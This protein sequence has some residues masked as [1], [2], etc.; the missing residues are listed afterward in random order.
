[1]NNA[2][3]NPPA[4][5]SRASSR[6]RIYR[7]EA[8]VLSRFD[9]GETDRVFTLLTRDRGKIRAIAKG[10]RKPTSKLAPSLDYFNRC[11]VM[12]SRG[13][14]LDV[15]TSV[16]VIEHREAFGERVTAF[17]HACHLAEVTGRL[18]PEGQDVPEVYQLLSAA[19]TELERPVE[20]W[21]LARWYEMALLT[22]TGYRLELYRCASC[23]KE[24]QPEPN[25]LGIQSGGVLCPNCWPAEPNGRVMSVNVQK[26]LRSLD[27]NGM[28]EIQRISVD[29]ILAA[30]IEA[31][32]ALYMR[33]IAERDFSSLRV[34][35][36]I[37]ETAP[38]FEV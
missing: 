27:R 9:M 16:E 31:T 38:Y 30:E 36:E 29:P 17:S 4:A 6:D 5:S 26:I 14:D 19:L 2:A 11:R 37:R 21:L 23:G 22:V 1:V 34:L 7:T 12:L 35:R 10:A 32:L 15:I 3:S 13:R 24:L 8:I 33:S 18:V 25:I 20:P 28:G